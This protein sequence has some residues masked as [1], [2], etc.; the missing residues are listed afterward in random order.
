MY[1]AVGRFPE[2]A[3][4]SYQQFFG[5]RCMHLSRQVL[6]TAPILA[7]AARMD[8]FVPTAGIGS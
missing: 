3:P 2:A 8:L 5:L 4:F 1:Q 7:A 6:T